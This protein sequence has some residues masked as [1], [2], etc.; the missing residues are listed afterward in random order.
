MGKKV[1][2]IGLHLRGCVGWKWAVYVHVETGR[3][4]ECG[5]VV[6]VPRPM[7]EKS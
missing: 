1:W 6:S 7:K 2:G 3:C 4:C 5:A